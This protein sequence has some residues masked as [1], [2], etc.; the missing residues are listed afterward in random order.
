[1]PALPFQLHKGIACVT[2]FTIR[3]KKW[4]NVLTMAG[5]SPPDGIRIGRDGRQAAAYRCAT[6][7]QQPGQTLFSAVPNAI[8]IIANFKETQLTHMSACHN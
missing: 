7:V 6:F 5:H 2:P 3:A 8:Y 1:M 4:Q